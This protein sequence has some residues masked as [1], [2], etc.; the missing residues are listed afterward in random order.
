MVFYKP[1]EFLV[2]KCNRLLPLGMHLS[3]PGHILFHGIMSPDSSPVS[4]SAALARL[5]G[6]ALAPESPV[7]RPHPW[8]GLSRPLL[9]A[10]PL[11][12]VLKTFRGGLADP[13]WRAAMEE[14]HQALLQNS[15]W[16]V[17]PR[18]PRANVVS[19]K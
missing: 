4:P 6:C 12:P 5:P 13:N 2:Y 11:S 14:E 9:H 17:V 3:I 18:P 19:G 1:L 15:T 7:L 10:A 8:P 16:V